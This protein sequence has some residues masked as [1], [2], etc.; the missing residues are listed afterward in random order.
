MQ[1]L[2]QSLS[3]PR[4]DGTTAAHDEARNHAGRTE[5]AEPN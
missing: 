3:N 2:Q 4:E 5:N 1:P